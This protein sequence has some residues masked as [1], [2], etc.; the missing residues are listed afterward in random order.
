MRQNKIGVCLIGAGFVG[1]KHAE[2]YRNQKNAVLKVICERDPLLAAQF[3]EEYGFERAESD[4]RLALCADDI[5]LVCVCTPNNT[6][7]QIVEEAVKHGKHVCCEKPLGMNGKESDYLSNLAAEK[8]VFVSCCY[9]L[10]YIPAITYIHKRIQTGELGRLVCFRGSYDNDR[11]A[12]PTAPFEWRMRKSIAPGGALC[13]LALNTLSISQLLCGDIRAVC[14]MTNIVHSQRNTPEGEVREVENDDIVQFLCTYQNGAMGYISSNRVAPGSK[15]DMRFEAQFTHGSIRF[16]LQHMNEV[17]IYYLGQ[18]G[19]QSVISDEHGWFC[20]G[21]EELK[22]IDAQCTITGI[23]ERKPSLTD[24]TF[25]AK[26][27]RIIEAVL[28]SASQKEWIDIWKESKEDEHENSS[29]CP[30]KA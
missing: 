14:G 15:Q 7:F 24:F 9:N 4:W 21:Y 23:M 11:L 30:N 2:A 19:Y 3:V 18:S 26:I 12:N 27:D 16:S 10:V 17:Q 28:R 22:A 29:I 6:H 25:A 13:D 1:R 20:T 8:G 5:D